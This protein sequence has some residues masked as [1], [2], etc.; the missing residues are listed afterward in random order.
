MQPENNTSARIQGG[1]FNANARHYY[2]ML[3]SYCNDDKARLTL[4]GSPCI[5]ST[6]GVWLAGQSAIRFVGKTA[7]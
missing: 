3:M 5:H 1:P 4:N 2:C 7:A 6:A